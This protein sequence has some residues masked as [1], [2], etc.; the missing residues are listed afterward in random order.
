M[1][2][3]TLSLRCCYAVGKVKTTGGCLVASGFA[4]CEINGVSFFGVGGG[5]IG[6]DADLEVCPG[7]RRPSEIAAR[8]RLSTSTAAHPVP[9]T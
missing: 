7:P 2:T 1:A 4:S 3:R 6:M 9:E 8:M 5:S